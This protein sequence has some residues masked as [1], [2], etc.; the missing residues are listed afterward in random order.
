M[1]TRTHVLLSFA[2]VLLCIGAAMPAQAQPWTW[3]NQYGSILNVTSFNP[4]TGAI[5]GTYTNNATGS[6][7]V[8][9]P[10]AMS[11]WLVQASS[12]TAISFSV[13]FLGCDS[14]T[15]WTGQLQP[16]ADFQ[17][18]WFLSLAGPVVWNGVSAGADAFIFQS[19]NKN[20]L[21]KH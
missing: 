5:S 12:G 20:E 7:G 10:Q 4:S 2:V 19:G 1:R 11:G 18:L 9:R 13:N 6:C 8:G 3:K 17:G 14:T 21:M 15:V 16:S